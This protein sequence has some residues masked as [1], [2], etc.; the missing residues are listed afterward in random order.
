M[1]SGRISI[2]MMPKA[3]PTVEDFAVLGKAGCGE[4]VESFPVD[5]IIGELVA[6]V[7]VD[8]TSGPLLRRDCLSPASGV[9]KAPWSAEERRFS[10]KI[11]PLAGRCGFPARLSQRNE[12][13][14]GTLPSSAHRRGGQ[15]SNHLLLI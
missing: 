3:N 8:P 12:A 5:R 6:V 14:R 1:P 15:E 2:E 9:A 7:V 10:K 13:T 4:E 11:R